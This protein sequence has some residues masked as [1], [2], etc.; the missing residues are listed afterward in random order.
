M[1]PKPKYGIIKQIF[2]LG[3]MSLEMTVKPWQRAYPTL[4]SGIVLYCIDLLENM[5]RTWWT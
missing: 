1:S 5:F 3:W 4:S 2:K